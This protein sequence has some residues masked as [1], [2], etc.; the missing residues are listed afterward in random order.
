[1]SDPDPKKLDEF[2]A[3]PDNVRNNEDEKQK[4][5]LRKAAAAAEEERLRNSKSNVPPTR[6]D[7]LTDMVRVANDPKT[8]PM[9]FRFSTISAKRYR[10][11]GKWYITEVELLFGQFEHGLEQAG[12]RETSGSRTVKAATSA[13]S[14]REHTAR[15]QE[16]YMHPSLWN[17]VQL[18][19][20][21]TEVILS[22]SD[23][24]AT[25]LS[26]FVW[27]CFL[28][29]CILYEPDYI[30]LNGDILEGADISR[31][32]KIPGWSCS[33]QLEFDF[34]REMFRQLREVA[35]DAEIIW[36]AGNHGLDRIAAY[37]AQ[38]APALACLD[39]LRFDKLAGVEEFGIKLA[40][41][42]SIASPAGTE[43]DKPGILIHD[44][45]IHHGTLLGQT[46]SQSE[47]RKALRSGQSGHVHRAG[48][49]MMSHEGASIS[50]MSTPMGCTP[51]AGR[52]YMKGRHT[53]W[54]MGFGLAFIHP[55]G[56]VHQYPVICDNGVAIFEGTVIE[57]PGLPDMDVSANWLPDFKMP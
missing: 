40:Q 24:H 1:M 48:M 26:P 45:L 12:L 56:R 21:G 20:T 54:Q 55:G 16:R 33:L 30:V 34:A 52:A 11:F 25:F 49:S 15:Y 18:E 27:H 43:N 7:L 22:I 35:P 10:R 32:P 53:G 6:E 37:L 47:L 39:N 14:R 2:L 28:R 44:Y 31:H 29:A 19:L 5:V 46:P 13:R 17:P 23:T 50:W 42:G 57:D 4:L 36:T 38:V 41:G 8:N 51:T 9:G 3:A